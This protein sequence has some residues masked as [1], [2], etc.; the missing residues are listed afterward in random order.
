MIQ[1]IMVLAARG[2]PPWASVVAQVRG[3]TPST[4]TGL[5]TIPATPTILPESAGGGTNAGPTLVNGHAPTLSSPSIILIG[6]AA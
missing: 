3:Q 2:H 6:Q 1:L 5:V 4:A